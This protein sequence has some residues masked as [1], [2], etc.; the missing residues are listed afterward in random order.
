MLQDDRETA[1]PRKTQ[2]TAH[3]T[4]VIAWTVR[5]SCSTDEHHEPYRAGL[6]SDVRFEAVCIGSAGLD[7]PSVQRILQNPRMRVNEAIKTN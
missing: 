4:Y 1:R 7:N 2:N 6:P 5:H 3:P